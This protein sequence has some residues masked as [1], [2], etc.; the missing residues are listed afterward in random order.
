MFVQLLSFFQPNYS[1]P[2]GSTPQAL[3]ISGPTITP[4]L[5]ASPLMLPPAARPPI[6]IGG[7]LDSRMPRVESAVNSLQIHYKPGS[8]LPPANKENLSPRNSRDKRYSIYEL[9]Q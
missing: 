6:Q 2:L 4:G 1:T 8:N 3:H 9:L 7:A 5:G